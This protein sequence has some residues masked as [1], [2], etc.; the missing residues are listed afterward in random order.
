MNEKELRD[1]A[2]K[3]ETTL[4]S[5]DSMRGTSLADPVIEL[6]H[7]ARIAGAVCMSAD[8]IP[9]A[10]IITVRAP[11]M[12]DLYNRVFLRYKGQLEPLVPFIDMSITI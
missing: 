3:W 8:P 6:H 12:K 10:M 7:N 11:E 4:S 1:D 2:H 9:Y 5:F